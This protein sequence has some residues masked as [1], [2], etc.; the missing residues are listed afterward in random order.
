MVKNLFVQSGLTSKSLLIIDTRF[1]TLVTNRLQIDSVIR[2]DDDHDNPKGAIVLRIGD[3]IPSFR[4]KQADGSTVK[5]TELKGEPLILYFYPKDDTPGCTKEACSL[6]DAHSVFQDRGIRI[7][8]ISP[9]SVES[10]RKFTDKYSLPFPLLADPD[11]EVAEKFGVWVEKNTYG[12]KKWGIKRTTFI[13]D[14]EGRVA[15]VIK[16][17]DT[18]AHGD[19]VLQRLEKSASG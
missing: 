3:K 6:R 10:H 5:S 2:F 17:V 1:Y 12:K 7:Y 11:H 14:E 4:L 8:G 19:Q 13:I 16:K 9:D 15:D 18:A